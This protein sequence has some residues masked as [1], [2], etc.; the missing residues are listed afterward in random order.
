MQDDS[1][2]LAEGINYLKN[3]SIVFKSMKPEQPDTPLVSEE[4]YLPEMDDP[5]IN[6]EHLH[7]YKFASEFVKDKIVLDLACGEGY[8][9]DILAAQAKKVIGIDID[10]PTIKHARTKYLKEN[11]EFKKSSITKVSI[12][13]GK[14]FDVII[15]FEALEHV[16]EQD[17]VMAEAKR[18]LTD[19]G[20]IILSTPNKYVYDEMNSKNP[21]HKK[22]LHIDELKGLVRSTFNNVLIYGQRVFPTSN[23]FPLFEDPK[24]IQE[25]AIHKMEGEFSFVS[26]DK[27]EA[28]YFIVVASNRP[29]KAVIGSSYLADISE[30][31]FKEYELLKNLQHELETIYN[32]NGWKF[33]SCYYKFRDKIFPPDTRRRAC[34]KSLLKALEA[35]SCAGKGRSKK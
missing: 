34:A 21:W 1:L 5:R 16:D 10:E 18:L 26:V 17:K 20:I 7:R 33:L 12:N 2:S 30:A 32:S 35:L 6:Y 14:L 31:F 27:K 13:E 4:R 15:C 22:E 8:G 29:I 11:L 19:D 24:N 28:R 9:S 25:L 3:L 23:I